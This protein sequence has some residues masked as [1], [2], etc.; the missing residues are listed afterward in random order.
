MLNNMVELENIHQENNA[1]IL[2]KLQ[3]DN[4]SMVIGYIN[5]YISYSFFSCQE[6]FLNVIGH[7]MDGLV[8][9]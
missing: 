3:Y 2:K 6:H 4:I 8:C 5:L 9:Y 1:Y 7:S